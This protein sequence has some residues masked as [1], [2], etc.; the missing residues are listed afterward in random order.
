MF[1]TIVVAASEAKVKVDAAGKSVG[2]DFSGRWLVRTVS[3]SQ[4]CPPEEEARGILG[5]A[6]EPTRSTVTQ[7]VLTPSC[8]SSFQENC[9][10][11]VQPASQAANSFPTE[12]TTP[13]VTDQNLPGQIARKMCKEGAGP[14]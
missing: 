2:R 12:P 10:K 4:M 13:M 6:V 9:Q 5:V 3:V 7:M 8:K 1:Q 11:R 14:M